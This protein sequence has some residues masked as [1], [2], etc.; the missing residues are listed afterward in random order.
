MIT[1]KCAT[2]LFA[3]CLLS[4]FLIA[5]NGRIIDFNSSQPIEGAIVQ[6]E[7]QPLMAVS[8]SDG[9]FSIPCQEG[10]PLIIKHLAY[11]T[12]TALVAVDQMLVSMKTATHV[13]DEISITGVRA[14]INQ[15]YAS[16]TILKS[17]LEKVNLGQDLPFLL[18][19]QPGVVTTSDAGNHVGYT[20]IRIRG[21]DATRINV[22]INGVP[23]NDAEASGVYWVDL[24][25][26]ASSVEGIQV[27]RGIGTSTNGNGAFGGSVNIQTRSRASKPYVE[28]NNAFGSFHT[29]KN[30]LNF[31]TG[32]LQN[33]L[34]ADVRLSHIQ[35]DGFIDR[36]SSKLLSY[37]AGLGWYHKSSSIRLLTWSGKERTGQAW[38]G[39]AQNVLDTN[40]TYNIAGSFTD[41]NGQIKFYPNQTDN[42][43]Q[44]Y[45]QLLFNHQYN[46]FKSLNITPFYTRGIGYYEEFKEDQSYEPYGL[47]PDSSNLPITQTT[48]LVRQRWLD[49]HF[50]GTT[51]NLNIDQNNYQLQW[52]GMLSQYKGLHFGKVKWLRNASKNDPDFE[53]YRNNATKNDANSYLKFTYQLRDKWYF[54]SDVQIRW[55][56]YNFEG[57][58]N[59]K[60]LSAQDIQ[61]TFF[62][63]KLGIT[64][65]PSS[66]W[67]AYLY[68]GQASKEPVRDDYRNSTPL[69]RPLPESMLNL[70]TGLNYQAKALNLQLNIYHM[71]YKNQLILNGKI[72][73]AGEYVR[74]NVAN[75]YRQGIELLA[76]LN[77]SKYWSINV[78]LCLSKNKI[79]HFEEYID[80]YDFGGQ[81]QNNYT[82]VDIAFSPNA[83]SAITLNTNPIKNISLGASYNMIGK[84]YLD[85][86]MNNN[87]QLPGYGF[88]TLNLAIKCIA[89]D[90][91]N[92]TLRLIVNN[93]F[94]QVYESNGYTFSYIY[95]QTTTTENYFYPQAG[96]NYMLG[97]NLSF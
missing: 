1:K 53:Y 77:Y 55:V 70:E 97:L 4:N 67:S 40:R 87:R 94:N 34:T 24:P 30:T 71:D 52:G 86:T 23:V 58:D 48:D 22:T 8:K 39:V 54:T 33:N 50:F 96:T 37:F 46:A 84:Q 79:S 72:N 36:A 45:Y 41:D 95:N 26:F 73:D 78:N 61:H 81:L 68:F 91:C 42:Y 43:T 20:G 18:N 89:S 38:Y 16:T 49:N 93:L 62:N 32:L 11:E 65:R 19:N 25:D 17:D 80:D 60:T 66:K 51:W 15:S 90:K 7:G 59:F 3:L 44:T 92:G 56:N 31:G 29:I 57:Y 6:V 63:P 28:V 47:I 69:S 14:G 85:N 74:Q 82:N 21:S 83:T 75:S 64:F 5:I 9:T 35:S 27:Q 13:A 12:E 10:Q 88:G 76:Q 2:L